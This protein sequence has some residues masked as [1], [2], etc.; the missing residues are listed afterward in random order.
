MGP[1]PATVAG[2]RPATGTIVLRILGLEIIILPLLA[3][4]MLWLHSVR[5]EVGLTPLLVLLAGFAL[6]LQVLAPTAIYFEAAGRPI[7]LASVTMVPAILMG[8]LLVY[9]MDGTDSARLTVL[10]VLSGTVLGTGIMSVHAVFARLP[11][12]GNLAGLPPDSAALVP[13]LRVL[14]GSSMAILTALFAMAIAYQALTNVIGRDADPR[15]TLVALAAGLVADSLVFHIV[16][17]SGTRPPFDW[18]AVDLPAK[19]AGGLVLWPF[20][21]FYMARNRDTARPRTSR[22]V[23]DLLL[24][25]YGRAEQALRRAEAAREETEA[26]YQQLVEQ[27]SD[28]IM[29]VDREARILDVNPRL[30]SMLGLPRDAIVGRN[31]AEFV[32]AQCLADRPLRLPEVLAGETILTERELIHARGGRV[33]VETSARL[34]PDGRILNI[35]RDLTERR[36]AEERLRQSE[37]FHRTLLESAYEV[38]TILERDGTIRYQSPAIERVLGYATDELIG[39]NGWDRVHPDDLD[40]ARAAW[41]R[42]MDD[43][44]QP[45][46]LEVRLRSRVGSWRTVTASVTNLLDRSPVRGVVVR[47]KDVTEERMLREQLQQAQKLESIG[48]LAG[49]VAHDFNNLLTAI[50]GHAAFARAELSDD[51]P[52]ATEIAEI[53]SAAERAAGLTQ[54]LLAFA[55]RQVN[56]PATVDLRSVLLDLE[57]ML[58][59]T[60]GEHV[61]LTLHA[62]PEPLWIRIDPGQ[63][64]Q[65]IVN[66]AVNG[67]DAMPDGG[68]LDIR[69]DGVS[70]DDV[71]TPDGV[72]AGR[73]A[74]IR[75]SDQG[76]G[77]PEDSIELIFEPFFTT[78]AAGTGTG[79]GLATSY[80]IIKQAGGDIRVADTSPAGTT[81]EI[82]LP[83][84]SAPLDGPPAQAGNDTDPPGA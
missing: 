22:N 32:D 42:A 9:V 25:E 31:F 20:A 26:R 38:T 21:W 58:R 14:L 45:A 18:V 79:L 71:A 44:G 50:L 4:V 80:G 78:K 76:N 10:A 33:P 13:D 7:V 84:V 69:M 60:I 23:F 81:M 63:L 12:A 59:R 57:T 74:R 77:I 16:V 40:A 30:A 27:A 24:G 35:L 28:G 5:R 73:Y 49:G 36:R 56:Q 75:I 46:D 65:V 43:P 83:F 61:E 39:S 55:R 68:R 53:T 72:S 66:L 15:A 19:L 3:A 62:P 47:Y 1:R 48:R 37:A 54:Q 41:D 34:L 8:L 70:V 52:V 2:P 29:L 11:G 51:G 67:R 64:E 6:A 82:L 17:G